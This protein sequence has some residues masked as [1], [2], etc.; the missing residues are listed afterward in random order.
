LIVFGVRVTITKFIDNSQ[1]GWVE[2]QFVDAFGRLHIFNEKVP[3]VTV[4]Y[5]DEKSVYPQDGIIACE[6]IKRKNDIIKVNI[7][8]PWGVE[9]ITGETIFDVF[10]EK[11][12]ES[13][14][15]AKSKE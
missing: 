6:I 9:S 13:E 2:C 1:P 15:L 12:I 4:E 8:K 14:H 5:L 7:E 10:N 11:I 3:I